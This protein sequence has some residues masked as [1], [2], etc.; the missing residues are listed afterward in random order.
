MTGREI[1]TIVEGKWVDEK[2]I[3]YHSVPDTESRKKVNKGNVAGWFETSP[4]T[5]RSEMS[6][7]HNQSASV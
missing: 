1:I 2:P 7:H 3:Y 5:I 6:E 4:Y